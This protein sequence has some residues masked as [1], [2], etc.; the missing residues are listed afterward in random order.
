MLTHYPLHA[1]SQNKGNFIQKAYT[2]ISHFWKCIWQLRKL[3]KI[4]IESSRKVLRQIS[5]ISKDRQQQVFI[6]DQRICQRNRI[7]SESRSFLPPTNCL[8]RLLL[9]PKNE[10]Y[11]KNFIIAYNEVLFCLIL[12]CTTI[13]DLNFTS[14]NFL[15]KR[16]SLPL[17]LSQE[18][19]GI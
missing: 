15:F 7:R 10:N 5:E 13:F 8:F 3:F 19:V 9:F 1:L 2:G 18:V 4:Y 12:I 11:K 14:F 17:S 16:F 6:C